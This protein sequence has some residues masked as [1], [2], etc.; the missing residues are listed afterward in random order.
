DAYSPALSLPD[1]STTGKREFRHL[2]SSQDIALVG[3]N[4]D[5]GATGFGPSA[6]VD[7]L[8]ARIDAAME[9]AAGLAAPLLCLEIGPLPAP[10]ASSKPKPQPTS[11]QAGLIILPEFA[12]TPAPEPAT[13]AP[14][15]PA[16]IALA[17]NVNAAL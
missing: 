8:I 11:Q 6:D 14:P 7:R 3:L 9:A 15:S 13:P 2:L 16:D 4:G 5:L 17:A 12:A 10:P 1:L